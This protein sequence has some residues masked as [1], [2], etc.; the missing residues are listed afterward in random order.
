M[1]E[2]L[3]PADIAAQ[4]APQAVA[5]IAVYMVSQECKDS[6]VVVEAGA[7]WAGKTRLQRSKV[8]ERDSFF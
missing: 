6:G 7:G 3:M 4:L 8:R 2:S 5:P 1:T